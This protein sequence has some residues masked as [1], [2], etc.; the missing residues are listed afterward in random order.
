MSLENTHISLWDSIGRFDTR[1]CIFPV[2]PHMS[3]EN[4]HKL[5]FFICRVS[6][7]FK[8]FPVECIGLIRF[9]AQ[10]IHYKTCV[11]INSL[12]CPKAVN[13]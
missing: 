3:P 1:H 12:L 10:V 5:M 2:A 8:M 6:A 11:S 13:Q 4:V 7:S 9:M